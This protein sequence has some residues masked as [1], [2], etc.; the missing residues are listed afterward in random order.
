MGL[1]RTLDVRR[2]VGNRPFDT[3]LNNCSP[4]WQYIR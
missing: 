2:E 1:G 3:L 4:S